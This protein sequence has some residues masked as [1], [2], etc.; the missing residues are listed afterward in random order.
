MTAVDK[1][2]LPTVSIKAIQQV[3]QH[4]PAIQQ[5]VIY[6]SRAKRNF[7]SGSDIY[8]TLK[9]ELGHQQLLRIENELDDLMLPYKIDL[10]LY[11]QLDN[12]AL[13]EHIEQVGRL[14]YPFRFWLTH[15]FQNRRRLKSA[16][17][18]CLLQHHTKFW[19]S[20]Y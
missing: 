13:L 16:R 5:A 12:P 11:R 17:K 7:H 10:S 6:G 15:H 20:R 14:L 19:R 18:A 4:Y 9:G 8:L 1:S 3:F 2:G